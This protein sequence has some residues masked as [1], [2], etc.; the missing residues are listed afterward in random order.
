MATTATKTDAKNRSTRTSFQNL[1]GAIL[2]VALVAGSG[3]VLDTVTPGDLIDWA[4]LG[5]AAG[6]AVIGAVASY[7]HRLVDGDKTP[8]R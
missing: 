1:L 4:T 5:A 7:V 6:T 8:I 2:S 3:A